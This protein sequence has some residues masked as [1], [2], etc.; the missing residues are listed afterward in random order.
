MTEHVRTLVVGGGLAGLA[1]TRCLHELDVDVLLLD[2]NEQP[3]HSWR[4]RYGNLRLNSIRW[5]S[6]MPGQPLP[7]RYGRWVSRDDVVAYAVDYARPV[8]HLVRHG[9]RV[10]GIE[11]Q[12]PTGWL[13]RTSEGTVSADDV[14]LA[15]GLYRQAAIPVWPGRAQFR[16]RLLHAADYTQ[17]ADFEGQRVLV[18]G[19]GVSGV[20]IASDLLDRS[21]GSLAVAVRTPPNLLPRELW[22]IPLQGL[23][24]TNRYAPVAVQDLGGRIVQR[25]ACG[26]LGRT[27]LGRSPEGMFTRLQRTGVN[28]AVDDGRFLP[29][30]RSGAIEVVDEVVGLAPDG[31]VTRSGRR[32]QADAVIAATGYRTG[33]DALLGDIGVLDARGVPPQYGPENARWSQQGLHFVGYSS[34]LTGHLREVRLLARRTSRT[35]ARRSVPRREPVDQL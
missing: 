5:L 1:V 18:V 16:G 11:R 17:P 25:L 33:L 30:V 21:A 28:P 9:V 32:V 4:S 10:S 2:E 19:P 27:P 26:D 12:S 24:V 35:I 8:E 23:S 15:T 34:P 13:V 29:A 20:D 3:A 14:V 6:H 22:S 31:A 7:R